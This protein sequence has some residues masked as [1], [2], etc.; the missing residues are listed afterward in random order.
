[1]GSQSSGTARRRC[2]VNAPQPAVSEA[3]HLSRRCLRAAT[4]LGDGDALGGLAACVGVGYLTQRNV[5]RSVE[6]KSVAR[7]S[8]R[9]D[10]SSV[11]WMTSMRC[12]RP[13]FAAAADDLFARFLQWKGMRWH[14][15]DG[16]PPARSVNAP[17]PTSGCGFSCRGNGLAA[18]RHASYLASVPQGPCRRR[19]KRYVVGSRSPSL[20]SPTPVGSGVGRHQH[21]HAR[22]YRT[23]MDRIQ[24][25][26]LTLASRP[27]SP[28]SA[29]L[30]DF[31]SARHQESTWGRWRAETSSCRH[32]LGARITWTTALISA[33]WVNAGDCPGAAPHQYSTPRRAA[34]GWRRIT[35]AHPSRWC[36]PL[37]TSAIASQK[38]ADGRNVFLAGKPSSVSCTR[39]ATQ[40]RPRS[41]RRR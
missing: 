3:F 4:D 36:G 20:A 40:A 14:N 22:R 23:M 26:E 1:M 25:I 38:R 32:L 27:A 31:A 6:V 7:V 24:R 21:Q 12:R 33:R 34:A 35:A 17:S 2:A 39:Y 19:T 8:W 30:G 18:T 9:H 41:A 28:I 5:Y 11:K 37:S 15:A 29:N 10:G 13:G 16:A